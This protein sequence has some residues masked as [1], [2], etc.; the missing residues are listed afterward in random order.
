M[1]Q[2]SNGRGVNS[3]QHQQQQQ[4]QQQQQRMFPQRDLP[5]ARHYGPS[6]ASPS[7]T[8]PS[9]YNPPH[10]NNTQAFSFANQ[11]NNNSNYQDPDDDTASEVSSHTVGISNRSIREVHARSFALPS[12]PRRSSLTRLDKRGTLQAAQLI[13]ETSYGGKLRFYLIREKTTIGRRDD[14][15]VTL[16][17]SQVSK[18]HAIVERRDTGY[19]IKDLKSANGVKINLRLLEPDRFYKLNDGD[20][21]MIAFIKL[22]FQDDRRDIEKPKISNNNNSNTSTNGSDENLDLVTFFTPE[23]RYEE[24]SAEIPA[25]EDIDFLKVESITDSSTLKEDYEKLRL[26]YELSKV[27][28]T[29][30]ITPLLAKAMDLMFEILP[31]DRGVVLLVDETTGNYGTH[32]VKLRE[33]RASEGEEI[34]LSSTILK[35]VHESKVSLITR[36]AYEDPMLA[37]AA[38]VRG[39]QIRCVICVPLIAHNKVHGIL[40]L[41]SKSRVNI[42]LS[43]KDISLV[44][45]ISN[46]TATVIENMLL[47]KEVEK[48]SRMTERLK[49]FL[50][51]HVVEKMAGRDLLADGGR[52]LVGTIIFVDIRGFTNFSE[53]VGPGEVV[54][55]LNDYFERLVSIVFKYEGVVDKYIGDALMAVFGSLEEE[56]DAEYR[57]VATALEFKTT[58]RE[59][60]EDRVRKG[61]DAI[62][63]G[64]GINTGELVAGFI[65]SEQRLEYTCIGDTV[66]TSSRICD[67]AK[68]DQ[69]YISETTYEAIK[70]YVVV[71]PVGYRQFKGKTKEVMIYEALAIKPKN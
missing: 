59:M 50:A 42:T 22:T 61:K 58:I 64:V 14:N 46:Q 12:A 10:A 45:A 69:V 24:I 39:L 26:A 27:V 8:T 6:S 23:Q 3:I 37:K 62:S 30:D 20:Q 9:A 5:L 67:M 32:Y 40:H 31:I 16:Q 11:S 70:D 47:I 63:I 54:S 60:N 43:S 68:Q 44:K 56:T 17:D 51:P 36:D 13:N 1:Q 18:F 29:N 28:L 35:K 33:G 2:S 65:G 41:D 34:L 15:D 71:K 19:Y 7:T 55:L 25:G 57:S 38:S 66:N 48:K 4:Q 49:R 53:K 21:V 52:E